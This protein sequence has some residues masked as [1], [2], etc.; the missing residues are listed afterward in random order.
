ME[1][2]A[3][4]CRACRI[5][6][7]SVDPATD[8]AVSTMTVSSDTAAEILGLVDL[9]PSDFADLSSEYDLTSEE[10]E[11][12]ANQLKLRIGPGELVR[13]RPWKAL[14]GLPYEVHTGRELSLMLASVKPLAVFSS[15]EPISTDPFLSALAAR[16][17]P[18]VAQGRFIKRET[19]EAFKG[20]RSY[21]LFYS[22]PH[23]R[24]RIDA[25]ILLWESF[26][27]FGW[28]DRCE[29]ME[30]ILL[31]YTPEQCDWWIKNK[32][33]LLGDRV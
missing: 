5:V 22:L 31:G 21:K 14:D 27:K 28:D 29:W 18:Y 24:W 10:A 25:M 30:G 8:C 11:S 2:V 4:V 6:I 23:E 9:E 13:L 16:F 19:I 20:N 12:V 7:E 15:G 1:R 3:P 33:A 32:G 26:S 17:S